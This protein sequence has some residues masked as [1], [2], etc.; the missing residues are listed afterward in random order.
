MTSLSP[1]SKEDD[2]TN[3]EVDSEMLTEESDT[4]RRKDSVTGNVEDNTEV[5]T[6]NEGDEPMLT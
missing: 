3:L 4:V 2:N 6:H 1:G 5:D